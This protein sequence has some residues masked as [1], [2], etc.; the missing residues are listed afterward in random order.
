MIARPQNDELLV[1]V[2]PTASGKS[3][4]AMD[5]AERFDA[6]IVGADSVQIYQHFDIGSGKPSPVDR[7]RVPHHLVDEIEPLAHFDAAMFTQRAED[8]IASIRAAG[9]V[10]IV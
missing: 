1:I 5:L 7:A 3:A 2:G 9:R 10:P 6:E 8:A 4:L